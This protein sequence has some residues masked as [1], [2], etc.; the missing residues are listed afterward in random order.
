MFFPTSPQAWRLTFKYPLAQRFPLLLPKVA[1]RRQHFFMLQT[2]EVCFFFFFP[3][4]LI[5][6]FYWAS[7]VAQKV[8]NLPAMQETRVQSLGQEDP[9]RG[10]WQPTPEFLPGVFHGQRSLAGD[11]AWD[12]RVRHGWTTNSFSFY[13]LLESSWFL[14]LCCFRFTGTWFSHTQTYID[15]TKGAFPK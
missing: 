5:L 9:W 7:L 8:T 1:T 3:L 6:I 13:F 14:L 4:R 10:E 11:S 12:R 15:S 2:L